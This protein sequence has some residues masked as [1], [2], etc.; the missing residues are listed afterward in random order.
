MRITAETEKKIE[1]LLNEMTTEE[2]V[3]MCHANSK[4][5]SAGVER[6]GIDELCM[7][8]G[9][10]GVRSEIMRDEWICLNREE[11]KCTYLPTLSA[12][13][14]TFNTELAREF[15]ETLGSEA[16]YRGKDII[17]GPDVNIMRTPLCGRNFEYMSE[18]PCLISKLS[19]ALVKGIES[20][21]VAACVKHFALN[22]QELNRNGVNVEVS[23]RALFEIY[24]KG[25][26]AAIIEG[27]ASSVMGAYNRYKQQYLCH[28]KYL[29]NDVLKGKWGFNGVYLSD[30]AGCHDTDE[31]VFNGLDLEMGTNKPYNE[32][33]LADAFLK[34]AKSDKDVSAI[35][36]DKVRRIL[37]LMFSVNKTSP[38]RKAG[39]FNTKAHQ[40]AAY[41][42]ASEAIVL[43]K[44]DDEFLPIKKSKGGKILVIGPNAKAK[45][46]EGGSSSGVRA[47]Y[48]V[49]PYEGIANRLGDDFE[50]DY[51]SGNIDLKPN[52]IPT[53]LLNI[54]EQRAGVRAFRHTKYNKVDGEIKEEVSYF[55]DA[56][57][58]DKTADSYKIEFSIKI[59]E[60]G[61]YLFKIK[62]SIGVEL[63]IN[64][65][66]ALKQNT[67]MWN[68]Q[69]EICASIE[70]AAKFS[71]GED[72][73]V[74]LKLTNE[75][76][77]AIFELGWNTPSEIAEVSGEE[78]FIK[79]VEAA[80]YVI[81]CGGLN[82]SLDTEGADKRNMELPSSQNIMIDRLVSINKNV[83]VTLTAGSPVEMPWIDKVKAVIWGWYAGMEGGNAL[84]DIL[85]GTVVPSGKM[86]FTLPKKYE[87]CP[88]S[89]YGEYQAK[90]CKYNEDI[91]VGYRGFDKDNITPL[92]PF[93]HGLSYASFEYSDLSFAENADTVEIS[94]SV[95]NTGETAAKETVQ[96]YFG[97]ENSAI[98]RA[99]KELCDF[100]K[101]CVPAGKKVTVSFSV[102]KQ[103]MSFYNEA[104]HSFEFEN[105][106]YAFYVGASSRDIRLSGKVKLKG[107]R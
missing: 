102:K 80:D 3:A 67:N 83:I 20:Q 1:K 19:P 17:L 107:C 31:A 62:S 42:I 11:D 48:E 21:D 65:K 51:E 84:A 101:I 86:P 10:H 25:F 63:F 5:T 45:H 74:V 29:V 7:M 64:G 14:A 76:K 93:G 89:R 32:Y 49:T 4:F 18:D 39:E 60:S 69:R 58:S 103:D 41:D 2:K 100:E 91:F 73:E 57:L 34:T 70:Y 71:A 55:A 66:Q 28:N 81:Y 16:R 50:V 43:L 35:L 79:K 77:N 47:L 52:Q 54:I 97:L 104:S 38:C 36:D 75:V 6:L 99:K 33:Y 61:T 40:K 96:V 30:W 72:A 82:H 85:C 8:D 105:G 78:Q 94:L 15:G 22:N 88:V 92:F 26:Y 13:A 90:N 56:V 59:P 46:A 106:E 37:R 23:E 98:P 27:G 9:P 12:L 24:L 44:N 95:K 68:A 87:D 53:Q